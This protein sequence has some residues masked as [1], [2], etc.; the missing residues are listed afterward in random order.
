VQ[1]TILVELPVI[2]PEHRRTEGE[3]WR[4]FEVAR[5]GIFGA[6][7]DAVAAAIREARNVRPPA[8][9]RM[10]DFAEWSMAAELGLGWPAGGFIRAYAENIASAHELVLDASPV[11]QAVRALAAEGE[12]NG[13]VAELLGTLAGR[14]DD[15]TR[16][17]KGWPTTPKA[18]AGILRRLGPNLR[19]VGVGVTFL[20]RT[21][22]GRPVRLEH[23]EVGK[24]PSPPT[25]PGPAGDGGDGRI[26]PLNDCTDEG[27]L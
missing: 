4:A 13:T 12:W 2:A 24:Q 27:E 18:L 17:T 20:E 3:F 25:P 6:L 10:A 16:R 15:G 9:P 5:P 19:A 23:I 1:R 14:V 7:L 26:P 21:K 22:R 11:A 8:L